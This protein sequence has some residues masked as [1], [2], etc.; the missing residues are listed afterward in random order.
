MSYYL[1]WDKSIYFIYQSWNAV[2]VP[3]ATKLLEELDLSQ[4][5]LKKEFISEAKELLTKAEKNLLL[6]YSCLSI[7]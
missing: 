1:R 6:L 3:E 5:D 7:V 2:K 4:E